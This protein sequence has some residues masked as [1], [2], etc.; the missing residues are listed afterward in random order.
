MQ[1]SFINKLTDV[2]YDY[3]K[4]GILLDDA[5]I[6]KIIE[7]FV[8]EY[9]LYGYVQS[10]DYQNN[11]NNVCYYD[12]LTKKIYFNYNENIEKLNRNICLSKISLSKYEKTYLINLGILN[13]ILRELFHS[14]QI[15]T[16]LEKNNDLDSI[17][18]NS[19][20]DYI[21]RKIKGDKFSLD[22]INYYNELKDVYKRHPSFFNLVPT[23]RMSNI[24]STDIEYDVFKNLKIK[25]SGLIKKYE[26][27]KLIK[28]KLRGFNLENI[29]FSPTLYYLDTIILL[30]NKFGVDYK[31][32]LDLINN[33]LPYYNENLS[34]DQKLYYGLKINFNDQKKLVRQ[35]KK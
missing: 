21:L 13:K 31:K 26:K 27:T 9:E 15:N 1:Y 5:A 17:I 29:D 28:S 12:F 8:R 33:I 10:V 20:Y 2:V 11:S 22:E 14:L 6:K 32:E 34:L 25:L 35:L 16:A 7:I 24:I 18:I 19:S 3:T 23:N 30:K 4:K